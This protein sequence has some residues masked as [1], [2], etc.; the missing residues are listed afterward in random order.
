MTILGTLLHQLIE[1]L[2]P[3]S[4]ALLNLDKDA[5]R[6]VR[7]ITT[8]TDVIIKLA[9]EFSKVYVVLDAFDECEEGSRRRLL[10]SLRKLKDHILVMI[11]SRDIPDVRDYFKHEPFLIQVQPMDVQVDIVEFLWKTVCPS[12]DGGDPD[13]IRLILP[14]EYL[15]HRI[16]LGLSDGANGM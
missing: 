12:E 2:P 16:R 11:V 5:N 6:F 1:G 7:Q 10:P 13:N 14:T 4:A 15:C 3:G 9:S 8:I